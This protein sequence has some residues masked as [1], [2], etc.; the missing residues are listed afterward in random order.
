MHFSHWL[1][2]SKRWQN[3][4]KEG[5][6]LIGLSKIR[7]L[8]SCEQSKFPFGS[9]WWSITSVPIWCTIWRSLWTQNP[10]LNSKVTTVVRE[11]FAQLSRAI[12]AI[13]WSGGLPYSHSRLSNL[14]IGL[15]QGS[16]TWWV[17]SENY[18][19]NYLRL[20]TIW[21]KKRQTEDG[22]MRNVV[23]DCGEE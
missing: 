3:G 20:K 2:M 4:G 18:L 9:G 15:Q 1:K 8:F 10:C 13:P 22:S 12:A 11:S 14:L 16:T 21:R 19:E 5:D 17:A 6:S 23:D 7:D